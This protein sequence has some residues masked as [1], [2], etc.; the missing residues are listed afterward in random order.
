MIYLSRLILNPASRMVQ[1]ERRYPY[2]MHRTLMRGFDCKRE[3]ANVLYRLDVSPYFDSMTLL[4]QSTVRPNWHPLTQV[5]QGQYLQA[6]PACKLVELDLPP[7]RF[8]QFRLRANP[9]IKKVRRKEN[10]ER[11]NSNRVPLV[12]EEKQRDWLTKKAEQSGF[13]LL[14]AHINPEGK[15]TD[16]RRHL[17]LYTIL[18][19]GHLQITNPTDFTKALQHG[20]GPGRAF[21]C[22]LLS[23]APA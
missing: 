3:C 21:G 6:P 2:E 4:I 11:R 13:K 7:G 15:Q 9:T 20:I 22:G 14:N 10:G 16:Y 23:L 17:T 5:G 19:N 18:I 12:R 1:N 8:L